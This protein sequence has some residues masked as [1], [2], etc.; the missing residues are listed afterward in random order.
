MKVILTKDVPGF[1]RSGE[2]KEVSDGHARNYLIP[3][4]LA[5]PATSQALDRLQKEQKEQQEKILRQQERAKELKALISNKSFTI[6]AKSDK[7]HLFA[8]VTALQI[9]EAIKSKLHMEI[10]PEQIIIKKPIKSL[11]SHEVEIKLNE[12]TNAKVKIEVTP[13]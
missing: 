12:S 4:H 6:A 13:A 9:S 3:R 7:V 8:A 10:E 2:V 5:L 1:G 11:G